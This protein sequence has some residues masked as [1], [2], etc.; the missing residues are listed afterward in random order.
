VR[1]LLVLLLVPW[2]LLILALPLVLA[3]WVVVAAVYVCIGIVAVVLMIGRAFVRHYR[4]SVAEQL[5]RAIVNPTRTGSRPPSGTPAGE[6]EGAP[7]AAPSSNQR[8][9]QLSQEHRRRIAFDLLA[10]LDTDEFVAVVHDL[11]SALGYYNVTVVAGEPLLTAL[12]PSLDPL[13]VRCIPYAAGGTVDA[14]DLDDLIAL[15]TDQCT[16]RLAVVSLSLLTE[17]A[18][19]LADRAHISIYDTPRILDLIERAGWLGASSAA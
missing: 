10:K 2:W 5:P 7:G 14:P 19:D 8:V 13:I 11:F 15:R 12:D 3:F 9:S 4:V 17:R 1:R 16:H 6:P 18:I